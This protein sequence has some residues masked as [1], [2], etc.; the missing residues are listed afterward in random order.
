MFF[1]YLLNHIS[2]R[3]MKF[4][5]LACLVSIV[6]VF[7]WPQAWGQGKSFKDDMAERTRACTADHVA[8]DGSSSLPSSSLNGFVA[9]HAHRIELHPLV[10]FDP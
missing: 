2:K 3:C 1:D 7:F 6:S 4:G 9:L 5:K 10:S 8:K